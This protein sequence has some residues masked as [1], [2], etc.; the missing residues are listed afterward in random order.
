MQAG[1]GALVAFDVGRPL[2]E[3]VA[4]MEEAAGAVRAGSVARASRS[5]KVG[6]VDVAEGEF[7]GLVEGEPVASG[8]V[9]EPVATD[10]VARLVGDGADVLTVLVGDAAGES[11]GVVD[12][13]R[14]AHPGLEVEV[15]E[16]GQPHYPLLFAVE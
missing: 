4:Q 10:V 9:L 8:G 1:L 12:A 7:L 5:A 13:I 6:D 16:G 2:D 15:H 3:N 11:D 14:A